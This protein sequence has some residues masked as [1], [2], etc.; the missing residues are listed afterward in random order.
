MRSVPHVGRRMPASF[1][2]ERGWIFE[3]DPCSVQWFRSPNKR[4]RSLRPAAFAIPVTEPLL[5]EHRLDDVGG[6]VG[7]R[8]NVV[9]AR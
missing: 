9:H 2:A 1:R 4:P 7:S 8:P 6:A 5:R 3:Q